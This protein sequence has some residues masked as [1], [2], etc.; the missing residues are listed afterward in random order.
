MYDDGIKKVRISG[1][2][3]SF[4][5]EYTLTTLFTERVFGGACNAVTISNDST[6]DT[7][8][9]SWDGAT[10]ISTIKPKEV[11]EIFVSTKTSVYVKGTAGGDTIRI[12]G[13]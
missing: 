11:Q 2:P 10:V 7:V 12:W 6:T 9:L 1:G 13:T 4:Y 5:E 3:I 8:T